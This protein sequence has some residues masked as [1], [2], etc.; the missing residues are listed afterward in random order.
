VEELSN[1]AAVENLD[2]MDLKIA[3]LSM[4][5][6][7]YDPGHWSR[8]SRSKKSIMPP[9]FWADDFLTF[10]ISVGLIAYATNKIH[11]DSS[12]VVCKQGR[13]LLHYVGHRFSHEILVAQ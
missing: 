8:N 5:E 1:T 7:V 9:I 13:P 3:K 2:S 12:L 10:A 4:K 6:G 11:R